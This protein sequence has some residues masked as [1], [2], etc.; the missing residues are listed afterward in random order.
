MPERWDAHPLG[1]LAE[2]MR[3]AERDYPVLATWRMQFDAAPAAEAAVDRALRSALPLGLAVRQGDEVARQVVQRTVVLALRLGR[4]RIR[5]SEGRSDRDRLFEQA[6]G[7]QLIHAAA[8]MAMHAGERRLESNSHRELALMHS[9]LGDHGAALGASTRAVVAAAD[10]FGIPRPVAEAP[11]ALCDAVEAVVEALPGRD[12]PGRDRLYDWNSLLRAM[13]ANSRDLGDVAGGDPLLNREAAHHAA[14]RL[15]DVALASVTKLSTLWPDATYY[16]LAD[17]R[18]AAS[19]QADR[20]RR[21]EVRQRPDF[22]IVV[23][24]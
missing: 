15:A 5:D 24:A 23:R 6:R 17:C 19:L 1:A 4:F 3:E 21:G 9:F 20:L 12:E 22:S 14:Q 7:F 16:T 18:D 10:R 2:T 8:D 11:H 13:A